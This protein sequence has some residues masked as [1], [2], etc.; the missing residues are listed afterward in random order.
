MLK[1]YLHF[2]IIEIIVITAKVWNRHNNNSRN[3]L[4]PR[5]TCGLAILGLVIGLLRA[6]I[7]PVLSLAKQYASHEKARYQKCT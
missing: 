4:T 6:N 2:Y 5:C 7:N 3:Q 1:I